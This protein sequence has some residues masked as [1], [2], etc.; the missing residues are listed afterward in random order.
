MA[1]WINFQT[2]SLPT[3]GAKSEQ[4]LPLIE[5][6]EP[7]LGNVFGDHTVQRTYLTQQLTG[8][9]LWPYKMACAEY[10]KSNI[11]CIAR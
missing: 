8:L 7:E 9:P 1:G 2:D 11:V 4:A 3:W 5:G 10:T 6:V